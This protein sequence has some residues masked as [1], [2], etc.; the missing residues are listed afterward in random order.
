M[1]ARQNAL[2]KRRAKYESWQRSVERFNEETAEADLRIYLFRLLPYAYGCYPVT[3][4]RDDNYTHTLAVWA[5]CWLSRS[6][7][8]GLSRH[9]CGEIHPVE[10]H[11]S[12]DTKGYQAMIIDY[13]TGRGLGHRY[14]RIDKK[15]LEDL[16]FMAK[17]AGVEYS[18]PPPCCGQQLS[19]FDRHSYEGCSSRLF[20]LFRIENDI[21][22]IQQQLKSA[23]FP[24]SA[25]SQGTL[26]V[27]ALI[28]LSR[29]KSRQYQD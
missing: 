24:L 12:C 17:A 26:S 8:P 9:S 21:S 11:Y 14:S 29:P 23:P 10:F 15:F 20:R 1:L 22:V 13:I 3:S 16:A 25:I 6:E 28:N 5:N 7:F 4:S 18:T 19:P 27:E 2:L